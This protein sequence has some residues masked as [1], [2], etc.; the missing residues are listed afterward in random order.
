MSDDA[1]RMPVMPRTIGERPVHPLAAL[2][3][4]VGLLLTNWTATEIIAD[5]LGFSPSLGKPLFSDV[6]V[7][8]AWLRWLWM[9]C[10][11]ITGINPLTHHARYVPT[12]YD[13]LR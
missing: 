3:L 7:P 13:S 10:N 12:V 9:A 4:V 11:P 2:T 6:Y 1:V 8:W 5:H